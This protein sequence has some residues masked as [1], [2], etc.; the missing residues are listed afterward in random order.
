[1]FGQRKDGSQFPVEISLSYAKLDGEVFAI[2]YISDDTKQKNLW[3]QLKEKTT[4]LE[5]AQ[6]LAHVGSLIVDLTKSKVT[7]SDELFRIFGLPIEEQPFEYGK[8]KHLVH[9]DDREKLKA[10]HQKIID[11]KT[12]I[13]L[14]YRIITPQNEVKYL[15]GKR[16]V[17][18]DSEGNAVKIVGSIQD[19]TELVIERNLREEERAKRAKEEAANKA[20]LL[21]YNNQL[22]ERVKERTKELRMH[23]LQLE[24]AL[25]KEK[26]LGELKSRFVSM[27][28]HEFRTPL[29]AIL[30]SANLVGLYEKEEHQE[31]RLKHLNRISSSVNNLTH[32]LNDFLSIEKIES[33]KI[34]SNPVDFDLL[35][36]MN[37]LIDEL[38][39]TAKEQQEIIY[40]YVGSQQ[41]KVDEHLL[42]NI[43]INLISNGIKYSDVGDTVEIHSRNENGLLRIQVKDYG[44][45]IP[46]EEQKHMF[47][48]FFRANNASAIQGTGL[49][50]TIVKRYLDLMKGTIFFSSV[51][52]EGSVFT[53]EIPQGDTEE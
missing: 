39:T 40:Q 2:A 26:E 22:E 28:S 46:K 24:K 41:V 52:G 9:P 49:G 7:W 12:G 29:T 15:E 5:D 4:E 53:V 17:K 32:L 13:N 19:V 16:D 14:G 35:E 37:H 43:L 47:T 27:A 44:M 18:F 51:L 1:M 10:L 33:G 36:F 42:K 50:L 21:E 48:Q 6:E 11:E 34:V 20:R 30:S 38:K 25:E 45:G 3:N 31:K 23:E 8:Y